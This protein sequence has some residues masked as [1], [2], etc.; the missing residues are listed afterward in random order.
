MRSCIL[1]GAGASFGSGG[2]KPS[3]PPLGSQV[4]DKLAEAFPQD[5]THLSEAD[6]DALKNNFELATAE[7]I[8]SGNHAANEVLRMSGV[9]FSRYYPLHGNVYRRLARELERKGLL[10]QIPSAT[11]NYDCLWEVSIVEETG[12]LCA[13]FENHPRGVR[14]LKPHGSCNFRNPAFQATP[15][16]GIVWSPAGIVFE[17]SPQAIDPRDVA[18]SILGNGIPPAMAFYETQKAIPVCKNAIEGIQTEWAALAKKAERISIVGVRPNAHDKHIFQPIIESS[19]VLQVVSPGGD[20]S[21][22][23]A[24]GVDSMRLKPVK[25]SFEQA[26]D[27]VVA[28]IGETGAPP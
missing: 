15:G 25:K 9:I 3:Q 8:K 26:V 17:G 22:W 12:R 23:T 16:G 5:W 20:I 18:D 7:M 4:A 27:E 14:V 13:Y 21:G 10:T 11:L 1:F 6:R 24:I 19:A 28:F 2:C